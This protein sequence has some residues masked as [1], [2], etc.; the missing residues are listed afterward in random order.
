MASMIL[1]LTHGPNRVLVATSDL[2]VGKTSLGQVVG[3]RAEIEARAVREGFFVE[4]LLVLGDIGESLS[5][6]ELCLGALSGLA[7]VQAVIVG[8][9]DLFDT[10]RLGSSLTRYREILPRRIAN[11]GWTWGEDARIVIP[12]SSTA[13]V[14]TTAWRDPS[15]LPTGELVD[16]KERN[17]L[18][19]E[20]PD[21]KWVTPDVRDHEL[22]D[23]QLKRF[24]TALG[25]VC[26]TCEHLVIASHFPMFQE[27]VRPD[28]SVTAADLFFYSPRF[29]ENL[30]SNLSQ[31]HNRL[32]KITAI[33]G[34]IHAP[35]NLILRR[36]LNTSSAAITIQAHSIDSKYGQ[37]GYV[38]V[39]V[40]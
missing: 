31:A 27:L 8:N 12:G 24:T 22:A 4:A 1:P 33:S 32:S 34:H 40:S 35:A 19:A 5:D 18:L 10:E 21:G 39:P 38:I 17:A 29:G 26:P 6:I 16:R 37:P 36:P 9:H 20:L 23:K 7:P 15:R 11:L 28:D 14:M 2:H 30:V 25:R 13:I 3:M